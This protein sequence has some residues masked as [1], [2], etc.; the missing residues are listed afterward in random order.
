M[1]APKTVW[2]TILESILVA[3]LVLMPL[4]IPLAARAQD[5][6]M[7]SPRDPGGLDEFPS[8]GSGGGTTVR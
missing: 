8:T 1:V 3:E 7:D 4:F 2:K 5:F 6:P